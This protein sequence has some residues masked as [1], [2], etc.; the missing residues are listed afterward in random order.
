MRLIFRSKISAFVML[1]FM[2][3]GFV[4][5][6]QVNSYYYENEL[7][8]SVPI[9]NQWSMDIGLGNRG[10]LQERFAGEKISGYQHDFLEVNHFT[11]YLARESVVISL[12]LRYRFSELFD[13]AE[14]NEFR[15]IEQ[16]EL[17]PVTSP[18]SHRFRLEQRF[19]EHTIHRM[20]YELSF[21]RGI[22]ENFSLGAGTEA[23][24]AI[25]A[26]LKPEAEQRF[27][28]GLENTSFENI[29]L[30]LTF[31]YRMEDY[32]RELGNEFFIITGIAFSL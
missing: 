28:L 20:R 16:V 12:G 3:S 2:G 29:E 21:S 6:Q 19:R 1:F 5:S 23:I 11:N 14:T 26:D 17:N 4:Y 27:S 13:A 32:L 10:L 8:I 15:I 22:N 30:E 25:S 24:Y 9:K 18:L 7:E 31:E